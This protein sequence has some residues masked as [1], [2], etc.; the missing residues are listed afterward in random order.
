[1]IQIEEE[2][3]KTKKLLQEIDKENKEIDQQFETI[4]SK[5]GDKISLEDQYNTLKQNHEKDLV[6]MD[7][8]ESEISKLEEK[9]QQ[10]V[11]NYTKKKKRIANKRTRSRHENKRI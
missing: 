2:D 5:V 10:I 6:Y 11:S 1:M 3:L 7:S 9:N 4:Q 8:I